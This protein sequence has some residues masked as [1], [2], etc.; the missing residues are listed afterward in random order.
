MT[1]DYNRRYLY[2]VTPERYAEMLAEQDNACAVCRT[3]KPGG[4]GSW[5]ID[6]DHATEAIRGLL[7]HH[8]N[9]GLGN[10]KDDPGYL[11]AAIAY[12]EAYAS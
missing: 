10:F 12:L 4:K 6:H 1:I 2:G 8:C 5:H 9:I 3:T 7:C 11:R